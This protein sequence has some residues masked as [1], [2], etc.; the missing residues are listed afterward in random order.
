MYTVVFKLPLIGICRI[1]IENEELSEYVE[2]QFRNYFVSR[3]KT[4]E[5]INGLRAK[6]IFEDKEIIKKFILYN[7]KNIGLS[8]DV[9]WK[10]G[11]ITLDK[12]IYIIEKN[13]IDIYI[14]KANK[15]KDLLKGVYRILTNRSEEQKYAH[16]GG[17]FYQCALFPIISIY[18]ACFGLFC[19]HGSLIHLNSG[20]NIILS[21]LDGVGK[22]TLANMIC[23]EN[24]N[25]LL[26]DNIVLFNGR[27]ALNF[28][29]AMRLEKNIHTE[30][31]VLY[32]NNDIIEVLPGTTSYGLCYI[33]RIYNLLRDDKNKDIKLYEGSFPP[34]DWIMFMERAPEIGQANGILSYWLFLYALLLKHNDMKIPIIS[35]S[36]PNGKL[37]IAKEWITA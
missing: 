11:Q 5:T 13:S 10:N 18:A 31:D 14:A 7:K 32:S 33:N 27:E 36:V 2:R 35:I 8:R 16:L 9:F 30:L 4:N 34:H 15:K 6:L 23:E 19:V 20:E 3:E 17:E 28:N 1:I 12:Y 26:A 25:L 21:G 24:G 37:S 22:S 29:I